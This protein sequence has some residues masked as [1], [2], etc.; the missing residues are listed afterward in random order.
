MSDG[1]HLCSYYPILGIHVCRHCGKP[2][3][4]RDGKDLRNQVENYLKDQG[5]RTT[6]PHDP[7]PPIRLCE[8]C[9]SDLTIRR[10]RCGDRVQVPFPDGHTE[11][12]IVAYADY[13]T[14]YIAPAGYPDGEV[15]IAEVTHI[16]CTLDEE[17][18]YWVGK[19]AEGSP[20]RRQDTVARL[21]PLA[22][23]KV[24]NAVPN[25]FPLGEGTDSARET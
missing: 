11:I 25:P 10:I 15:K 23:A 4:V 2:D 20:G 5:Y 16:S 9:I 21:Y 12:W 19:W 22:W 1:D 6:C 13:R 8:K 3:N 24:T 7:P 17:H 18:E 14:G